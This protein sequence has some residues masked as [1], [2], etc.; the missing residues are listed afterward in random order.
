MSL[1]KPS[2]PVPSTYHIRIMFSHGN[3]SL[4]TDVISDFI[5]CPA[6][7]VVRINVKT[8]KVK[9]PKESSKSNSHLVEVWRS[10]F[11]SPPTLHSHST[12]TCWS[13]Q[14]Y[15]YIYTIHPE[16]SLRRL[17]RPRALALAFLSRPV[18][19]SQWSILPHC[20][21]QTDSIP[22]VVVV[23][24]SLN[25][26]PQHHHCV[27]CFSPF[28]C[29]SCHCHHFIIITLCKGHEYQISN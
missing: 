11:L 21:L 8:L 13:T 4:E 3:P 25:A 7:S 12:V 29:K 14:G 5:G 22:S 9:I 18:V 17:C 27:F 2:T 6:L 23:E 1:Q 28:L 19:L 24:K 20:C 15:I 26:L 10:K 16:A